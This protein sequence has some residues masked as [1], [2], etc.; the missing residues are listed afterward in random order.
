MN[1]DKPLGSEPVRPT[2]SQLFEEIIR[3]AVSHGYLLHSWRLATVEDP[4]FAM[5]NETIVAVFERQ[6]FP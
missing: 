3:D 2:I 4:S 5:I 1:D 6:A